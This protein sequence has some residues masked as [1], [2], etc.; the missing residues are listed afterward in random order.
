MDRSHD[1]PG[2]K[3]YDWQCY[4]AVIQRKPGALRNGA[5]FA[6]LPDAFGTLQQHLLRNQGGDRE[7]VDILGN[8]PSAPRTGRAPVEMALE[9]GI[10]PRHVY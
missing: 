5:P 1:R 8:C 6:E 3:V 4:L 2:Q 10:Q 7:T 9:A